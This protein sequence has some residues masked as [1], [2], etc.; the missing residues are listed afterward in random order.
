MQ[1]L[2][3]AI[4]LRLDLRLRFLHLFVSISSCQTL[5]TESCVIWTLTCHYGH[6]EHRQECFGAKIWFFE[7]SVR[8]NAA[9]KEEKRCLADKWYY[10]LHLT[11]G[12]NHQREVRFCRV[13]Q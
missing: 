5:L 12:W 4:L 6:K 1:K 3:Q 8:A 9:Y 13:F 7:L 2:D 10:K 11:N